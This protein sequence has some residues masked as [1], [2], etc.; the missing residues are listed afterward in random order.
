[1][2]RKTTI[3]MV[4]S[5]VCLGVVAYVP[6][7]QGQGNPGESEIQR[8]FD[9]APVTL[10]LKGKNRGLVGL[11]SYYVNGVSDCLGCHSGAN[12]YLSGG[13]GFGNPPFVF[14]RNLTPDSNGLPGGLTFDQF[15][16]AMRLG[17]DF[18]NL[19]PPGTLVVMPWPAF[20]HGTDHFLQA[21]YEYLS[22]VPCIEGGPGIPANRC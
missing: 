10:E 2:K 1:M 16:Q 11:G 19:A 5:A 6:V 3:A 21:I 22:S 14:S 12:G 8:G 13:V 15:E 20:R 18:K 4:L 7:I 17:T 9:I